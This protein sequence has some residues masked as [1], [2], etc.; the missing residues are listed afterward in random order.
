MGE[1]GSEKGTCPASTKLYFFSIDNNQGLPV[2]AIKINIDDSNFY[3]SSQLL[4]LKSSNKPI[5][6]NYWGT[7]SKQFEVLYLLCITD[8]RKLNEETQNLR[9]QITRKGSIFTLNNQKLGLS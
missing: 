7:S 8:S 1:D 9:I 4:L 3:S 2:K 6:P 5:I